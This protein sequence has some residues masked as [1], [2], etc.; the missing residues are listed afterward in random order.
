MRLFL[1]LPLSDSARRE[2]YA[3]AQ[4]LSQT[5]PGQYAPAENYHLTLAFLG[6]TD[7]KALSTVKIAME[8]ACETISPFAFSASGVSFF[9]KADRAI[10]YCAVHDSPELENLSSL[11]R[12][13]L[14]DLGL[15]FDPKPFKPHITLARKGN[16]EALPSVSFRFTEETTAHGITLFH[17][18]RVDGALRYLPIDFSPFRQ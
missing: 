14:S 7:E 5:V 18:T 12:A 4:T 15:P 2:A 10:L 13:S 8:R 6:D 3:C 17:S 11:L 16:T 1:G 9:G